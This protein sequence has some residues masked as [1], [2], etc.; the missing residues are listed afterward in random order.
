M[1]ESFLLRAPLLGWFYG[2]PVKEGMAE[3]KFEALRG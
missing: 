1:G 2:Y 3:P